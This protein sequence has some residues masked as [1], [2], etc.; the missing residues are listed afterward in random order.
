MPPRPVTDTRCPARDPK[1]HCSRRRGQGMPDSH[2]LKRGADQRLESGVRVARSDGVSHGSRWLTLRCAHASIVVSELVAL[3][4]GAAAGR[5]RVRRRPARPLLPLR[6]RDEGGPEPGA[7]PTDDGL[8]GQHA[9]AGRQGRRGDRSARRDRAGPP[10][11]DRHRALVG[12]GA[13]LGFVV[14][15][16]AATRVHLSRGDRRIALNLTLM[17]AAAGTAWLATTWL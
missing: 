9:D 14:L 5:L 1:Q 2:P 7:A 15:Q 16:I 8:G 13:A 17:F 4:V 10:A 11:A 6:G 12:S 3:L